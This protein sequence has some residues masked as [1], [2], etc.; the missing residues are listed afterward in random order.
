MQSVASAAVFLAGVLIAPAVSAFTYTVTEPNGIVV[1]TT[2]AG[3]KVLI[4][5]NRGAKVSL[6]TRFGHYDPKTKTRTINSH[7]G[8]Y[9]YKAIAMVK[10]ANKR[11]DRVRLIC[12]TGCVSSS[13]LWLNAKRICIGKDAWFGFH[14][15]TFDPFGLIPD[16]AAEMIMADNYP[17]ALRKTFL[18][19][20]RLRHGWFY[21]VSGGTIRKMTGIKLCKPI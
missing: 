5:D 20:W 18:T 19:K 15:A 7:G 21:R 10:Q 3:E 9:I 17:K 16:T 1:T 4:R 14:G 6:T 8:G 2:I 11:G 12:K 13:T